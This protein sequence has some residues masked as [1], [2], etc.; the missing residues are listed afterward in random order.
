MDLREEFAYILENYGHHI[1][2]MHRDRKMKC[3]CWNEITKEA[4]KSCPYCYGLGYTPIIE[5]HL[6]REKNSIQSEALTK[7]IKNFD[8]GENSW[9]GRIF[10]LK[11]NVHVAEKDYIIDVQFDRRGRPLLSD[12]YIYEVSHIEKCRGERGRIEFL[13]AYC[14]FDTINMKIIAANIRKSGNIDVY[15]LGVRRT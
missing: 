2:L 8:Y 15:N 11:H 12:Y 3:S 6:S 9:A 7:A 14:S 4:K 5:K 13:K 10:Y 1:L